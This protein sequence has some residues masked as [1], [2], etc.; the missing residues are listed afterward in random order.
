MAAKKR[1]AKT[2]NLAE[3][4]RKQ[5]LTMG[6]SAVVEAARKAGFGKVDPTYVSKVRPMK[7]ASTPKAK[8]APAQGGAKAAPSE[9]QIVR[10]LE[11]AKA[12]G[13]ERARRLLD[14]L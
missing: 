12:L 4:I 9:E 7:G 10:F 1:A 5:P 3:W 6:P 8:G 14:L 2:G 11:L 13:K